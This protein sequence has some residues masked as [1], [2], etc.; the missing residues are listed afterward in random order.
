MSQNKKYSLLFSF[1]ILFSMFLV[2]FAF[3]ANNTNQIKFLDNKLS[4]NIENVSLGSVI[5]EIHAKTGIEFL[6]NEEEAGRTVSVSFQPL[7]LEKALKRILSHTNHSIIFTAK[8]DIRKVIIVGSSNVPSGL[9]ANQSNISSS[10][11]IAVFTPP[12]GDMKVTPPPE[13]DAMIRTPS[14][15]D[16]K[17]TPPPVEEAMVL[18]P[19]SGGMKVTPPLK[20]DSMSALPQRG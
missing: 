5:S 4:V 12:I 6:L 9:Q 14:T 1:I 20:A 7:P 10:S 18:T 13:T 11:H 17:I 8:S 16:M 2:P 15:K 3:G 19:P